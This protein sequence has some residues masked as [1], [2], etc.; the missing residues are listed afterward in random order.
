D[1]KMKKSC[2]LLLLIALLCTSC[3]S[4]PAGGQ[5]DNGSDDTSSGTDTTETLSERDTVKS[6]LPEGLKFEGK[7]VNVIVGD[8]GTS[9]NDIWSEQTGD[10][11]DDAVY[12]RNLAVS[13]R[14]GVTIEYEAIDNSGGGKIAKTM[15][16]NVLA[17]DEPYQ[18]G[19]DNQ[20]YTTSYALEGVYY[21]LLNMKYID[22]S[23]PY[24]SQG[25]IE[26]ATLHN[27]L[28]YIA[29]DATLG[30]TT[31]SYVTFF[32][33]KLAE[34]W[35]PDTDLYQTVR[36]GKWTWDNFGE[37]IKNIYSDTNGDGKR[38]MEDFYG[39][40][41]S[42]TT[43]P[44]DAILPSCDIRIAEVDKDGNINLTLNS[45]RTVNMYEML[46]NLFNKN[47][48]VIHNGG[49]GEDRDITWGKFT[50]SQSVF[51]IHRLSSAESELRDFADP[52]GLLPIPKYD[53]A[54]EEYY[55][56]PH[57][58][59][60]IIIVPSN[61]SDPDLVGAFIEELNYESYKYVTPA[62]FETALKSKYLDGNDDAEMYDILVA[63]KR[64]DPAVIYSNYT[65]N[66]SWVSRKVFQNE[67]SFASYYASIETSAKEKLAEVSEKLR[68]LGK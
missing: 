55:T 32:N 64:F 20:Y 47:N 53:E 15:K 51:Y 26:A 22:T 6:S 23:A 31:S 56:I 18:L 65:G 33:K 17:G 62:Y 16:E 45:E 36:D 43:S 34:T 46:D 29:G 66:L 4:S 60:S 25:F 67:Q 40:A 13:E 27:T 59:Y 24:Y 8:T 11:V 14:L 52:Y 61:C 54:Q 35:L 7:T 39:Y 30:Q 3:N 42:Y 10:V 1:T 12:N 48:G 49:T 21:N 57:D 63:G 41:C 19:F 2:A 28:F 58:M 50:N 9:S 38:D 37:M 44:L 68:E 5:S